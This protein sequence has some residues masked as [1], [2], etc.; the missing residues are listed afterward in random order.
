MRAQ[1]QTVYDGENVSLL[2][3]GHT[4]D[5]VILDWMLPKK[6]GL[7]V[8]REIRQ[9]SFIPVLMLT[10]RNDPADR[11]LGLELG[12]DDYLAKPIELSELIARVRAL[13]RRSER[14]EQ[15]LKNDQSPEMKVQR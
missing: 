1:I 8:L 2:L 5:L 9:S 15:M 10:A 4:F 14:I 6:D 13:F 7:A 11:V 3:K 12:A